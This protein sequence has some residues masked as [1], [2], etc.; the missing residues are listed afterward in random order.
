[1]L[2]GHIF[3]EEHKRKLSESLKNNWKNP[4]YRDKMSSS[5]K[6]NIPSNIEDL[7]SFTKSPEGRNLHSKLFKGKSPW[8]KGKK[9][10]MP[11]PWNKGLKGSHFSPKTEFKKGENLGK[12]SHRWKGGITPYDRKERMKFKNEI[13]KIIF[14]R[15]NYSCQI[16]GIRGVDL[17]VDHIQPW[18]EYIELRFSID[19]C[20]TLCAK[21]HYHITFGRPMPSKVKGWGH[22]I[23]KESDY[24]S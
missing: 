9:G 12:K 24:H 21:C 13:Q 17:Q 18:A 2:K 22:N 1:M 19:N 23:L 4:Q 8:N 11:T 5:H 20:R 3:T 7:I 15:D 6:G 10:V 14:E 16:C